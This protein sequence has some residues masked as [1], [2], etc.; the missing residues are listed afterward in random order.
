MKAEAAKHLEKTVT[1]LPRDG[2]KSESPQGAS[3]RPAR[4][5]Q[6]R[7]VKDFFSSTASRYFDERYRGSARRVETY[8]YFERKN[9]ILNMLDDNGGRVL[10]VGCGPGILTADLLRK[11]YEVWGIDLSPNMVQEGRRTLEGNPLGTNAHFAVGNIERLAFPDGHFDAVICSGILSYLEDPAIGLG[12]VYR[13]LKPGGIAIITVP[14][15]RRGYRLVKDLALR[16]FRPM[17]R[18]TG[19]MLGKKVIRL[20]FTHRRYRPWELDRLVRGMGFHKVSSAHFHFIL[21]PFDVLFPRISFSLT[22]SL[23]HKLAHS[24]SLG[25]LGKGYVLKVRKP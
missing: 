18:N 20:S 12:E 6:G 16:F 17:F 23:H 1:H 25:W 7:S 24:E 19:T 11:A 22:A 15:K 4:S 3:S 13:V 14:T 10:D 9:Y 5:R 2:Q 21:F 8:S